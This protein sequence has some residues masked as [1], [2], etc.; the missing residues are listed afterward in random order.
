[1]DILKFASAVIFG[2]VSASL[3]IM[4]LEAIFPQLRKLH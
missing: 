1:M 2:G 4:V 3:V